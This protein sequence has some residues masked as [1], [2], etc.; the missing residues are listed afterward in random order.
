MLCYLSSSHDNFQNMVISPS[1]MKHVPS[2]VIVSKQRSDHGNISLRYESCSV[3]CLRL[4][5]TVRAW[6][7][8]TL[9]MKD[10]TSV[11]T[12]SW[13]R[14]EYGNT[15]I[16][17]ETWSVNCHRLM[18]TEV[19]WLFIPKVWIMRRQLS[20]SHDNGQSMVIYQTSMKH[21]PSFVF[22]SCQRTEHGYTSLRY[23]T[24]SKSCHRLMTTDRAW[25]FIPMACNMLCQLLSSHDNV[26]RMVIYHSCM[27]HTPTVVIV[28][29]Q[30]TE[31]CY[32]SLRR[33][34]C[35][36]SCYCLMTTFRAWI[37]IPKLWN[38]LRLLTSSHDNG[39]SMVIYH[40]F[41]KHAPS[42][43]I[44]SWQRTEHGNISL[45]YET[46]SVRWETEHG[47]S[48]LRHATCSV[49]SYRLMTTVRAW[50]FIPKAWNMLC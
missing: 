25:L 38:L 46:C 28:S 7:Y 23:E 30:R 4:V 18:T 8:I 24:C 43:V 47:N 41:M 29:W 31:Y 37:F 33:A 19:A 22:A 9:S 14:S 48:S 50:L 5:T 49:S 45:I 20:S 10:A 42:V 40:L 11:V 6:W 13:Q 44:A 17:N 1:C 35:S 34:T 26:Q 12:L 39:Q 32:S 21:V 16:I 2:V 36:V 27:K 15:S 3:I